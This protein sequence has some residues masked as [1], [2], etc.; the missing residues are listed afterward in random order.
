V[1]L[2]WSVSGQ[3]LG[4]FPSVLD[5]RRY[6]LHGLQAEWTHPYAPL[7]VPLVDREHAPRVIGG[8]LDHLSRESGAPLL[9]LP[10]L[11]RSAFAAMLHSVLLQNGTNCSEFDRHRRAML[12]PGSRRADYLQQAVSVKRRKEIRRLRHRLED[13][14][15]VSHVV[16]RS[17]EHIGPA[18]DEFLRI[19]GAGWKGEAGTAAALRPQTREFLMEAVCGLASAGKARADLLLVDDKAIAAAI[20]LFSGD[21]AWTW[22]IAYDEN[23][24]RYSPG[25]QLLLELTRDLLAGDSPARVDSCAVPNHP[26]IDAIWRE[27][28]EVFD[29]LVAIKPQSNLSFRLACGAE[30]GRRRLVAL[31]K[32]GLRPFGH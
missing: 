16:A 25:V 1:L 12:A 5:R 15:P 10:M 17:R 32:A 27:R 19:E 20:S 8:W 2:V 13:I 23:F 24:A 22:K 14:G 28:L 18:V 6:G 11:P 21:T 3:L 30:S 31:A 26:M 7:G 9:L 29:L 4:F